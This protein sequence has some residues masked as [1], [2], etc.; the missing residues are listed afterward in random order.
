MAN[1]ES[2][3]RNMVLTL[4]IVTLFAATALGLIY[5][6]TKE[7]IARAKKAKKMEAIREVLPG[8]NN[9][10]GNN[11]KA[12]Q[13][14]EDSV[15]I[16]MAEMND[17]AVGYAVETFTNQG[18]SGKIRIMVGFL[19][20]GEINGI[21]VIQHQETPGLGSKIEKGKSDFIDQFVGKDPSAFSLEVKKDGG[22]VDAITAATITS[23]AF[24]G[25]VKRAHEMLNEEGLKKNISEH[26]VR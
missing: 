17:N 9:N 23:R 18:Y 4:G 16:Y 3:F 25:A 8:F 2:S 12:Y 10:P 1:K 22:D 5:E 7:P 14:G 15:K 24:C 19:P 11:K 13:V 6:L 20:N 21:S 26:E